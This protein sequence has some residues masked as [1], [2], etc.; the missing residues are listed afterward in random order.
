MATYS[1]SRLSTFEQCK[2]KYKYQYI[3]KIKTE[4]VTSIEAYMGD[5]CHQVLE[6]LYK[7]V[8][9]QKMPELKEL[10]ALYNRLWEENW[11]D[12]IEIVRKEY[13]V[14]NY[15]EMGKLFL[16]EYYERKKPFDQEKTLA[17]ETSATVE[18]APDINFH[19]RI[20]R[21]TIKDGVYEIHDYKTSNSLPT[22]QALDEERQLTMYSYGLKKLYPNVNR[23]RQIW[24]YLAF[25][26]D[27]VMERAEEEIEAER[28][29]VLEVVKE[30]ESCTDYP[31]EQSALCGW[32][33]FRTICPQFKHLYKT[34]AMS[35]KELEDDDGVKLVNRF[36]EVCG[37]LEKVD[38]EKEKLRQALIDFARKN[39]VENVYGS[40]MK[41][42][43][44]SYPKLS[45]PKK[46]DP[47]RKQ[48]FDVLKK[49]GL[50]DEL[51]VADV[52]EL[53]KMINCGRVNSELMK[54]LEQYIEKS[55]TTYVNLRKK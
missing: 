53:T 4:I 27:I 41:V 6:Q 10:L 13:T 38:A 45:F 20:D 23:I 44:R 40:E 34:E 47:V 15:K 3:D 25:N 16:I 48:F 18:I 31:A 36:A 21:L 37:E 42:S 17:L 19:I 29:K 22:Q 50:W 49:I 33:E 28:N 46:E 54:F 11:Q 35:T 5:I 51:A 7:D 2:L 24:H 8:K 30:I 9:H 39:N 1:H 14:D 43:V 26:E 32:C 52:Y 55:E 12:G